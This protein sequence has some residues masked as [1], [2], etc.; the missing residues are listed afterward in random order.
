MA[1]DTLPKL[2]GK[3]VYYDESANPQYYNKD[4]IGDVS[5]NDTTDKADAAL[6]LRYISGIGTLS[7]YQLTVAD[8]NSDGKV[9]MLDVVE[10]LG[11]VG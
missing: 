4:V 8:A 3:T 7:D 11:L 9:D 10:I 2:N 1:E 5:C 6:V